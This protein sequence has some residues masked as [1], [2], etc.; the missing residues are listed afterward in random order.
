MTPLEQER[1][2]VMDE[3]ATQLITRNR[4][5]CKGVVARYAQTQDEPA[6]VARELV[7][8]LALEGTAHVA[9]TLPVSTGF[10]DVSTALRT[11]ESR[12]RV[13]A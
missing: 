1:V 10:H 8:M 2:K 4:R 3:V 6:V 5:L 13:K 12:R 7:A 11:A 9:D